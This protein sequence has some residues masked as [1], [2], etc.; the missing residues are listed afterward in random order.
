MDCTRDIY[1]GTTMGVRAN[2]LPDKNGNVTLDVPAYGGL[3][4]TLGAA[5]EETAKPALTAALKMA[6]ANVPLAPPKKKTK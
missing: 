5:P 6:A 4:F 2:I 1:G 3:M